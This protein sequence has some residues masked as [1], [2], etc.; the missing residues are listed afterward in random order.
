MEDPTRTKDLATVCGDFMKSNKVADEL[1]LGGRA[2]RSPVLLPITH[3]S[4]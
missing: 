2:P 1:D 4:E 3:Y